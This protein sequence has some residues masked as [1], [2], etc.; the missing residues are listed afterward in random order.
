MSATFL[1]LLIRPD[2]AF[3]GGNPLTLSVESEYVVK[4]LVLLAAALTLAGWLPL[5][6]HHEREVANR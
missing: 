4:N 1:V 2:V 5:R 6:R 3:V